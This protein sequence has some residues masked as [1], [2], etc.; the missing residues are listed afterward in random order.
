LKELKMAKYYGGVESRRE[1]K[2][3]QRKEALEWALIAIIL[4]IMLFMMYDVSS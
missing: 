4:G 3:R 1:M 2:K